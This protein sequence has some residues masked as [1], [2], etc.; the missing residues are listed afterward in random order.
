MCS[1]NFVALMPIILFTFAQHRKDWKEKKCSRWKYDDDFKSTHT[2]DKKQSFVGS[3]C[4]KMS[5]KP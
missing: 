2:C 4:V 3:E 5:S 1:V